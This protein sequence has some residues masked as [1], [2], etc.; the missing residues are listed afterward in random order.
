VN[1]MR[2]HPGVAAWCFI[3][4][5]LL[6]QLQVWQG[7]PEPPQPPP[8]EHE[9]WLEQRT[10]EAVHQVL[11]V[12]G[13]GVTIREIGVRPLEPKVA[14]CYWNGYQRIDISSEICFSKDE[15]LDTMGHECVHAIFDQARLRA[16]APNRSFLY[17][18]LIEETAAYVLGAHIAGRARSREGGDG[19]ALTEKLLRHYR[20]LCDPMDPKNMLQKVAA[21]HGTDE[22]CP[23]DVEM[24]ISFHFG[25]PKLV[26]EIDAMCRKHPDPLEAARAIAE[27]YLWADGEE[28]GGYYW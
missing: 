22:E 12:I 3:W 1:Q 6:P 11:R 4:V 17:R 10:E 2:R 16:C 27:T 7:L 26:D 25:S 13:H 19:R 8:T 9:A 24:S 5:L 28:P 15:L 18:K 20:S 14:A 23:A 21:S